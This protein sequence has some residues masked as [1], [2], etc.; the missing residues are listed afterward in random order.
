[1]VG[2]GG[3]DKATLKSDGSSNGPQ[4]KKYEQHF[5]ST[6][7]LCCLLRC[8]LCRSALVTNWSF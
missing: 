2:G 1:M 3:F 4:E 5:F 7:V 6:A 8:L